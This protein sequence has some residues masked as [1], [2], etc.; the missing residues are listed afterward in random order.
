VFG[1][2][3]LHLNVRQFKEARPPPLDLVHPNL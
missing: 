2:K 3:P 1:N